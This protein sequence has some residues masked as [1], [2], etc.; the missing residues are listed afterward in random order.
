MAS[1][2]GQTE[3]NFH[4]SSTLRDFLQCEFMDIFSMKLENQLIINLY[5]TEKVCSNGDYYIYFN[6]SRRENEKYIASS[7]MPMPTW[8]VSIVALK[9]E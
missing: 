6:C 2:P 4:I 3:K 9:E 1:E 5:H 7:N 8:L